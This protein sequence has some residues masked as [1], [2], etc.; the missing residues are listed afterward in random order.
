MNKHN[1]P[2]GV[3][4]LSAVMLWERF[5]YYGMRA[6]L[7]F[8]MMSF[9]GFSTKS[10]GNVYGWFTGMVYLT[11]VIG[12]Y[13]SD[14]FW[15]PVK[16]TIIGS[17]VLVVGQ[18]LM[19]ILAFKYNSS[20]LMFFYTA[21]C[22]IVIGNG[23]F[24]P[25]I[26]S[27]I[28]E[29]YEPND[30]RCDGGFTI[31]YMG[32]NLGAFLSPFIC[33]YLGQRVGWH[34]GFFASAVGM[35]I[36]AVLLL[37]GKEKYIG[38]KGSCPIHASHSGSS[39]KAKND[40]KPLTK[41][42]KQRLAVIVILTFFS[43]FFWAA[44]EQAGSSLSLFAEQ[45]TNKFIPFINFEIPASWFQALNPLFIIILAP[46]FSELWLKLSDIKKEPSTPAKF[47]WSLFLVAAGFVLMIFAAM[48]NKTYGP[49]SMLWLVGAYFLHTIGE[50]CTSPVGMSM[51]TKLS[52]AKFVSLMMGVFLGS[53]FLASIAGGIFAGNYDTMDHATF[54]S[55][56]VITVGIS[57]L[58][59][60]AV[61]RPLK[62]WM[63]G[64]H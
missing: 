21:M 28:G 2:K 58:V 35:L 45:S 59:L 26:S 31:L 17:W 33:G 3:Y 22:L 14:R 7:V 19:S 41:N 64:V 56:P 52:P 8:F 61:V 24:K 39:K 55:V 32:V 43:V 57:G 29:Y 40:D 42:E 36:G 15:G 9:L 37:W 5:S 62:R 4:F 12:G 48:F 16:T 60:L 11:P 13:I 49:V 53:S 27:L 46:L 51:V 38:K 23:L 18:F 34:W 47:I 1:H 25:C 44:F 30:P 63:H 54:F 50:L 20:T 6:L 10:F